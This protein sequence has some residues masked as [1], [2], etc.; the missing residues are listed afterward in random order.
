MRIPCPH[1]G[2]RSHAEFTY[3]G[4]AAPRRP[5]PLRR[6]VAEA[7]EVQAVARETFDYVYLRDNPPGRL[8]EWWQHSGGCR[9]WVMVERD[10][11]THL[12]GKVTAA[13][14]SQR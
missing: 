10:V 5:Q 14:E 13:R 3:L 12:L 7:G 2:E 4:D 11:S 1:C 9:A 8:R 6:P